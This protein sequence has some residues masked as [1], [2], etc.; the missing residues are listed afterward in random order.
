MDT[1]QL[2]LTFILILSTIFLI[3]VGVQLFF[4]LREFRKTLSRIDT[5]LNN[6]ESASHELEFGISGV[7]QFFDAFKSLLKTLELINLLAPL[8]DY[9]KRQHPQTQLDKPIPPPKSPNGI[10]ALID[11]MRSASQKKHEKFTVK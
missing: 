6:V 10:H 5:I 9:L 4:A 1:I 7:V 8:H 3:A 2:F 11:K